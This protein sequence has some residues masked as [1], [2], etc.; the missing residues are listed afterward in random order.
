MKD[1]EEMRQK[2]PKTGVTYVVVLSRAGQITR[3]GEVLHFHTV[4]QL[5]GMK[6]R[7]SLR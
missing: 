6:N 1:P 2:D 3:L 7:V 5:N 4:G